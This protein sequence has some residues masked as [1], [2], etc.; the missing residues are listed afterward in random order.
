MK[1]LFYCLM[2]IATLAMV[3]CNNETDPKEKGAVATIT[4]TETTDIAMSVEVSITDTTAYYYCGVIPAATVATFTED[5]LMI[6]ATAQITKYLGQYTADYL[7]QNGVLFQGNKE[8]KASSL[9]PATEYNVLVI[10]Y[11]VT[12]KAPIALFKATATTKAAINHF[13]C[14][15]DS[16]AY[17]T[18]QDGSVAPIIYFTIT[19]DDEKM[20]YLPV[21]TMKSAITPDAATYF[22]SYLSYMSQKGQLGQLVKMGKKSVKVNYGDTDFTTDNN[23]SVVIAGLNSQT[24]QPMTGVQQFDF[25]VTFPTKSSAP[26]QRAPEVKVADKIEAPFAIQ[27][28]AL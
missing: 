7:V 12:A 17:E 25:K 26:M 14:T 13:Q 28:V 24:A 5:S 6:A 15:Y 10:T 27:M 20:Y 16:A 3:G 18:Q 11:D 23:V 19:P 8:L 4:V 1:K 22:K 21:F 9:T 2:A